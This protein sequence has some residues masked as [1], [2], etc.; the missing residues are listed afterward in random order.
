MS[1]FSNTSCSDIT[2]LFKSTFPDSKIAAN[3]AIAENK[4]YFAVKY[5]VAPYFKEMLVKEV[6]NILNYV[7]S[8]NGGMWNGFI[9][10][11]LVQPEKPSQMTLLGFRFHWAFN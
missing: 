5:A 1:I 8:L 7:T 4:I 11:I 6:Q 9:S 10:Q 3:F 2:K